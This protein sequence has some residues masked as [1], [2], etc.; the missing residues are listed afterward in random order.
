MTD[1]Y[2]Y[3]NGEMVQ[4]PSQ[5]D[6]SDT[7]IDDDTLPGEVFM[8]LFGQRSEAVL[9][10]VIALYGD[11]LDAMKQ[12]EIAEYLDFS[13][14]SVSRALSKIE[15]LGLIYRT[16]EGVFI[17]DREMLSTVR[18]FIVLLDGDKPTHRVESLEDIDPEHKTFDNSFQIPEHA[19]NN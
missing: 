2:E 3:A 9:L 4:V 17:D 15:E 18:E 7:A 8:T 10:R 5:S 12:Y 16:V 1:E 14:A 11:S 19:L 6:L 13:E